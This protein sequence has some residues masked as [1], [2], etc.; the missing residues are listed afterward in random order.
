MFTPFKHTSCFCVIY[1]R[2]LAMC[3]MSLE[4]VAV[5]IGIDPRVILLVVLP[6]VSC[7]NCTFVY[8]SS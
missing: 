2:R 4:V 1:V 3:F 7:Q 8:S 5:A 6:V